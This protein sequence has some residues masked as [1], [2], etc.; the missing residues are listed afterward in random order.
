MLYRP[1][2][3]WSIRLPLPSF[4]YVSC[5]Y[6]N[7]QWLNDT[8]SIRW[9]HRFSRTWT[10]FLHFKT[11]IHE[12]AHPELKDEQN[13]NLCFTAFTARCVP[14]KQVR[15]CLRLKQAAFHRSLIEKDLTYESSEFSSEPR[16][17]GH[18]Q[19]MFGPS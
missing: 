6:S 14:V 4:A 10:A 8:L 2:C 19:S 7:R 15:Y 13:P 11:G 16:V 12:A 5:P 18:G 9:M 3:Q 1:Y 17:G